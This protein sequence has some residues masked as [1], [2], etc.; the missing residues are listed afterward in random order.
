MNKRTRM[1]QRIAAVISTLL[2]LQMM[3]P[4]ELVNAA[5]VPDVSGA[6]LTETVTDVPY[7]AGITIDEAVMDEPVPDS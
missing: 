7:E 5:A 6:Y 3:I 2:I 1:R 4:A